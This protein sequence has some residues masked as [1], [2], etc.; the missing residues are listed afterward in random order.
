MK[1]LMAFVLALCMLSVSF[2]VLVFADTYS[3][4]TANN[5][6]RSEKSISFSCSFDSSS[7]SVR[8]SGTVGHAALIAYRDHYIEVYAV[9]QNGDEKAIVSDP[10]IFAVAE[11]SISVKF[12]FTIAI[13]DIKEKYY[14]YCV[15]LRSPDG[16]RIL[17][18]DAKYAEVPSSFVFNDGDNYA[19]KGYEGSQIA[20]SSNTGAGRIIMPIYLNKLITVASS[21]YL[22][23]VNGENVYF[24]QSYVEY[25]DARI[26]T[27]TASG[28]Q[29]YIRLLVD[30]EGGG[31]KLMNADASNDICYY[32]PDVYDGNTL[33]RIEAA[34]SY[35]FERYVGSQSGR[36]D[37]VVVGREIDNAYTMN[38]IG[39]I[40]IDEYANIYATYALIVSNAA[41]L[42]SPS[43][44]VVIPFSDRDT[45]SN[46]IDETTLQNGSYSPAHL[47]TLL[48]QIFDSGLSA[49][50][51]YTTMI[52]SDSMP[53]KMLG[54]KI[55]DGI[56]LSSAL[57]SDILTVGNIF[58]YSQYITGMSEK[59]ISAPKAFM[60]VWH[61]P[62][63]LRSNSLTSAY[64]YSYIGLSGYSN[65]SSF[66][67]SFLE[68]DP[69]L[70]AAEFEEMR[71]I[72]DYIDTQ[73]VYSVI[74]RLLVY[75][76]CDTWE[77]VFGRDSLPN[78]TNRNRISADMLTELPFT[79][80]GQFTY[81][82]FS[83]SVAINNWYTG[84]A[85]DS[86]RLDYD[87]EGEMGL[88]IN[89]TPSASEVYSEVLCLYDYSENFSFT[90]YVAFRIAIDAQNE[91][92]RGSL[93]EVMITC[94][95]G[96]EYAVASQ[97][98]C[99]GEETTVI[100]D[101]SEYEGGLTDHWK[102]SIRPLEDN[103]ASYSLWVYDIKGYSAVYS[104]DDLSGMIEEERARIRGTLNDDAKEN[105]TSYVVVVIMIALLIIALGI[106]IFV[107]I[108]PSEDPNDKNG[109]GD[110]DA[111][112]GFDDQ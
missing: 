20:S 47:H 59:Y 14:G 35:L 22:Y 90:P 1:K 103:S 36:I 71:H 11:T 100:M 21:G 85:C 92:E 9:P 51:D 33:A 101:I 41:R 50:L 64:V 84:I 7:F 32:M 108:R 68:S 74:S 80:L 63:G 13:K 81:F 53:F 58:T 82:D 16:K 55:E 3:Q 65:I 78:I 25:L 15:A 44:D 56:D 19:Y 29:V 107:C 54:D 94:G 45:Y 111:S 61:V 99:S 87:N 75:F 66:V 72:F 98:V 31:L 104:S 60:Y 97:T 91:T 48:A 38:N 27:A 8:L 69:L 34:V 17:A 89:M 95:K 43:I 73:D 42:S 110:S 49:G 76:K 106:G 5:D 109:I 77:E 26:R 70:S 112:D 88:K 30:G 93:Y 37:G 62:E 86:L 23:R 46:G 18:T 79:P 67:V 52:E 2:T 102:I 4:D 6:I 57:E 10:S 83:A 28:A 24:E 40:S 12:D 39:S 105:K 96:R